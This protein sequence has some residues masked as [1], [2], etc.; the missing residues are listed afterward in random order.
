MGQRRLRRF[1]SAD[2]IQSLGQILVLSEKETKHLRE[3]LRLG[4]SDHCLV[5]DGQGREAEASIQE[6]EGPAAKLKVEK[7]SS[8]APSQSSLLEIFVYPALL[9]KGKM[10]DL[11]RQLQELGIQSFYPIETERTVAKMDSQAKIRVVQRW[12]KIAAEA[13]KQSGTLMKMKIGTPCRLKDKLSFS[14]EAPKAVFHRGPEAIPFNRWVQKI[15]VPAQCHLFFGPEG[16]W[17]D[18]ELERF[19]SNDVPQILLG[20]NILKA[21]TAIL[22]V[23]AALK[24]LFL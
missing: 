17:S 18:S 5:A 20:D 21:D 23:A 24:L 16:G 14:K 7:W 19:Q 3:T 12:E 6:F 1:L 10:D 9:Q 2:P 22:S 13:C 4:P 11:V 15:E 8:K